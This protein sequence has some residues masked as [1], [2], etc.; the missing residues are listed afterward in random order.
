MSI[1]VVFIHSGNSSYLINTFYQLKKT[2]PDNP[3]YLISTGESRTYQPMVTYISMDAYMTEAN[4]FEK[5][6]THFSTNSESFERMC[7][8]R[9]FVLKEFLWKNNID[10]CLYLDSDVLVYTDIDVLAEK[11]KKFGM[12]RCGISGHTNFTDKNTL[13]LFCEF[14][15]NAY[16]TPEGLLKLN[17]HYKAFTMK[18]GA[19]G[20][21][22][23]TFITDFA[24]ACPHLVTDTYTPEDKEMIDPSFSVGSEYFVMDGIFKKIEF[25]NKIPYGFK[26]GTQEPVRFHTIHFQGAH[27]KK[28]MAAYLPQQ[29]ITYWFLKTK[30]SM[31]LLMQKIRTRFFA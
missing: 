4:A 15:T 2:N 10:R 24:Y 3:V 19:G 7:I 18:H 26:I 8:Q 1:P 27:A 9:W 29:T 13:Q 5:I 6:Y 23:M 21:S 20:V 17:E 30:H 11:Y 31:I 22:D 25:R 14:V 28:I 12:T 16:T